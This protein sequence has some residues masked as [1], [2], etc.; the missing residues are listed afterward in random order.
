MEIKRKCPTP[1]WE[2]KK[3]KRSVRLYP[4]RIGSNLLE[5]GKQ[6]S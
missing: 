4:R 5:K 1:V 2:K 3:K 6:N